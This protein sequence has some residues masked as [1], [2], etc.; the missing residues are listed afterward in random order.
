MTTLN[1]TENNTL[2]LAVIAPA[3]KATVKKATAKKTV[4]KKAT[5]KIDNAKQALKDLDIIKNAL[6]VRFD[7]HLESNN[8][9]SKDL[10][11]A[12]KFFDQS[13]ANIVLENCLNKGFDYSNFT[14]NLHITVSG[15]N[16]IAVKV[17]EKMFRLLQ[18]I[19]GNAHKLDGYTK[20]VLFNVANGL[21]DLTNFE[22]QQT[23]SRQVLNERTS[24]R[25]TDR[26]VVNQKDST[27]GTAST[28]TSSSRM[29]LKY[30]N[31]ADTQKGL[32]DARLNI[33]TETVNGQ[34]FVSLAKEIFSK[35]KDQ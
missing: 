24:E 14:N 6:K 19:A 29:C 26:K 28:Q 7:H 21:L 34:L 11:K 2:D 15:E 17:I 4:T 20:A 1:A 27:I 8:V 16:F 3:K 18:A 23:M 32:K 9:A 33:L 25:L 35:F 30:L 12:I 22:I 5:A 10:M 31:I 13:N